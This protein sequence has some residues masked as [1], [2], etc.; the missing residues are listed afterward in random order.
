[1]RSFLFDKGKVA[2]KRFNAYK[3]MRAEMKIPEEITYITLAS[4]I[5]HKY[6]G[7]SEIKIM[8]RVTAWVDGVC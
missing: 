6:S 4:V 7:P 5:Q 3:K 2:E 1:L 8:S